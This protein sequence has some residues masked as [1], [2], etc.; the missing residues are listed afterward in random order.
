MP[1]DALAYQTH[2]LDHVSAVWNRLPE[3]ARGIFYVDSEISLRASRMLIPGTIIQDA[4]ELRPSANA[5]LVASFS[6]MQNSPGRRHIL[7][8]HGCGQSYEP[9]NNPAYA[10]GPGRESV[11][12]FLCPNAY[13]AQLN[14]DRYPDAQVAI[15]GSPRLEH[16]MGLERVNTGRT[17]AFG[18]HFDLFLCDETR[19]AWSHFYPAITDAVKSG[20]WEVLGHAH[21]RIYRDLAPTFKE[22]DIEAVPDFTEIVRRADVYVADNSSTLFEFAAAV[23]PV[24]VMNPPWYRR[25]INHGLRF[26]EAANVGPQVTDPYAVL[27]AAEVAKAGWSGKEE[28]LDLVFPAVEDPGATAA[29]V[30]LKVLKMKPSKK[31]RTIPPFP[32]TNIQILEES[33]RG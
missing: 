10:G 8:E 32:R 33:Q 15:I 21:P 28:A 1:I 31:P 3:E 11:E 2:Y 4:T 17:L 9:F 14:A 7:M 18:F 30:I 6:D 26:W 5:V 16:L 12:L 24:V 22:M 19:N 25:E 20:K 13:S 29:E 23:G 27:G